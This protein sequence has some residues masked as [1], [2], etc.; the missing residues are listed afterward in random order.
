MMLNRNQFRVLSVRFGVTALMS[1]LLAIVMTIGDFNQMPVPIATTSPAIAQS[2]SW[3]NV[4]ASLKREKKPHRS[5]GDVCL[6]SP[7]AGDEVSLQPTFLWQG[8]AQAIALEDDRGTELWRE[9][10]SKQT[11][12]S[13]KSVYQQTYRGDDLKAGNIY[14]V[15]LHGLKSAQQSFRILPTAQATKVNAEVQALTTKL[16]RQ[17]ATQEAIAL[18]RTHYFAQHQLWSNAV[19]SAYSVD[20]PSA[21]LKQLIQ[22]LPTQICG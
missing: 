18:H 10:P 5:R 6:V 12:P 3:G 4:F 15:V 21:E 1:F 9:S 16:Q 22:A 13:E 14:T 2:L 19:Q 20:N 11:Q 17:G 7:M 8:F